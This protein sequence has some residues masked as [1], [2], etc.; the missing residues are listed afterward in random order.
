MSEGS[1]TG[2]LEAGY[3]RQVAL[4]LGVILAL[5]L[6]LLFWLGPALFPDSHGYIA[7]GDDILASRRWL[8][9][10]DWLSGPQPLAIVRPYGYPLLI[11]LAKLA[12]GDRFAYLVAS[13]QCMASVAAL[14]LVAAA[15]PALVRSTALRYAVLV[16]AA[17]SGASLYDDVILSDSLYASLFILVAFAIVLDLTGR[18][19]LG[20]GAL[21]GLGVAWG[22]SIWLRDVGLYFTLFPLIG[23]VLASRLHA[24]GSR[25]LLAALAAFLAPVLVL[26]AVHMLWNA[27]RTGHAFLSVA[28]SVNWLWPSANIASLGLGDPF[29]GSD[30]VSQAAKSHA[31]KPGLAG[32]YQLVDLLWR[33][34]GLDPAAIGHATFSHFVAMLGRHPFAYLASVAVNLQP[35]RL[36][37][38]LLNPLANFNDFLQLGPTAAPRVI[39]GVRELRAMPHAQALW[40]AALLGPL[41]L[42][43]G[44]AAL[45]GLAL[46]ALGTP[47]I[48][49]R[50]RH[51]EPPGRAAAVAFLWLTFMGVTGAFALLHLEMRYVLPVLPAALVA[52]GYCLDGVRLPRPIGLAS[53]KKP[54]H[55]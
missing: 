11:A 41:L 37:D 9:D 8:D 30:L 14:A 32:M 7:L 50:R 1:A 29:D 27:H 53:A 52:L 22:L 17:V 44:I 3:A 10:G 16:L 39:P 54:G 4:L 34:Y 42:A 36:A 35:E 49:F 26:V 40:H 48:A 33:D 13:I 6:A 47:V 55:S 18:V 28:A 24:Q 43:L 12:A 31:I 51:R 5:K 45:A 38:F 46:I 25:A 2:A 19:R 20:A 15:L 21:A 23:L